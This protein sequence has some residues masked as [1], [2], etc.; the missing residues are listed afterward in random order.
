M[1]RMAVITPSVRSDYELCANLNRSVLVNSPGS[2]EHHIVVPRRDLELF[3]RLAGPRTWIR[4]EVDCLPRSFVRVPFGNVT[5]NMGRPFPP[6]RGWILQQVVK[7][8]AVAASDVDVVVLVDSDIEF[9]RPF[10]SETFVADRVARFYRKPDEIDERLP[11]HVLWHR[12][13][14][15]LLGLPPAE[16]PYPDYVSS[17]LAWD[18]AIVRLMLGRVTAMTGRP[19]PTSIAGQLHFSEWTLYGVFVDNLLGPA[20]RSF[21]SDDA[22]CVTY[23][24]ETPLNHQTAMEFVSG[25]RPTDVA[26]MISAKSKTPLAVRR[27]AF[28][29]LRAACTAGQ[30][31]HVGEYP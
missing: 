14:R 13:A 23:W 25:L 31:D 1:T 19:W 26:G 3:A 8:A 6:V 17:L 27:A 29:A 2:V 9:L 21:A 7:L 4:C 10:S 22:L 15:A 16:P 30:E 12:T 28:A 20:A 24:G 11:R 18:P 5:I